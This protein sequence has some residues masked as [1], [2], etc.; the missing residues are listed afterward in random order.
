MISRPRLAGQAGTSLDASHCVV[1]D[2]DSVRCSGVA[3]QGRIEYGWCRPGRRNGLYS[4]DIVL[5]QDQDPH[6]FLAV[7]PVD[8][9][10]AVFAASVESKLWWFV[11]GEKGQSPG[12]P[13]RDY[14]RDP[15][16]RQA[17]GELEMVTELAFECFVSSQM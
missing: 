8:P 6:L 17:K 7:R 16:V 1:R 12:L 13:A 4:Q 15:F 9:A 14:F 3:G 10:Q 2:L 5:G 11:N